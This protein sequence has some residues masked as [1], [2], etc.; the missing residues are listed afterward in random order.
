LSN[1][2]FATLDI[3][4]TKVGGNYFPY[5][6]ELNVTTFNTTLVTTISSIDIHIKYNV[7]LTEWGVPR[8]VWYGFML[9][10]GTKETELQPLTEI[11]IN[12][13]TVIGNWTAV[14][15]PNDGTWSKADLINLKIGIQTK[16]NRTEDVGAFRAFEVWARVYAPVIKYFQVRTFNP[17]GISGY[18]YLTVNINA[19]IIIGGCAY[20]IL[21]S[22]GSRNA[23]LQDWY[24]VPQMEPET[25]AWEHVTEPNDGWWD[26]TDLTNLRITIETQITK[27]ENNGEF[28]VY[29]ACV[30]IQPPTLN[31]YPSNY[32]TGL[33]ATVTNP[34]R[35][36]DKNQSSY[37]S[38]S[39]PATFGAYVA[40][41]SFNTTI[42][43]QYASVDIQMRYSV[44]TY[45]GGQYKISA[46]VSGHSVDLQPPS[47][48]NQTEPTTV[49]W[50]GV[51][52]PNDAIWSQ[53]DLSNLQVRVETATMSGTCSFREYETWLTFPEDSLTMRVYV[54]GVLETKQLF[55]WTFNLTFNKD[56]LQLLSVGDGPF[57]RLVGFTNFPPIAQ[58]A[59]WIVA[60]SALDDIYGPGAFGSGTLAT[61]TFK[62]IARGN[63]MFN[64]TTTQLR[65]IDPIT[66]M[67]KGITHTR[68]PGWF[69]YLAGDVNG[70]VKV[71]VYDLHQLGEAYGTSSG[72][73]S[74]DAD[75]DQDK[76]A[77]VDGVD[78]TTVSDHYGDT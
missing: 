77:D 53:A 66:Y 51:C 45:A 14:H 75:A 4:K 74:Y 61:V 34:A 46:Y 69:Q 5:L 52:E 36:Y 67:P 29:E 73:P 32:E 68:S 1:S 43:E 38:I 3:V 7:T 8:K 37:A 70:D 2:S 17:T 12:E 54:T 47:Y 72:N 30:L 25:I 20:K 28:R 64:F 11:Q 71:D 6:R 24:E 55:G 42:P 63:S 41:K 15:E 35:A 48:L 22:V 31:L 33:G 39:L 60:T 40:V 58:G 13:T 26:Q 19:S 65:T 16:P 49:I 9:Y 59:G 44:T 78:L 18:S 10:V 76:D 27:S 56:V 21:I 23:T 50:H 57:L 62:T